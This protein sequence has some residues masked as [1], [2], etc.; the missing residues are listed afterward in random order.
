MPNDTG[1]KRG[2][3]EAFNELWGVAKLLQND[4][5]LGGLKA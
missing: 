5:T 3:Y 1:E 4:Q 2:P